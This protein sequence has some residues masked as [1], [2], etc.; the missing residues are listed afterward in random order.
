MIPGPLH[1]VGAVTSGL[2][3]A[4]A[5]FAAAGHWD[6][7]PRGPA[8]GKRTMQRARLILHENGIKCK[9][10]NDGFGNRE[11]GSGI[12]P[13]ARAICPPFLP[14]RRGCASPRG[15]AVRASR[16][17]PVPGGGSSPACCFLHVYVCIR[18]NETG[19]DCI[20]M[21]QLNNTAVFLFVI[22]YFLFHPLL[23][24]AVLL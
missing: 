23:D 14:A 11:Q 7:V 6:P 2:Q 19:D 10:Q 5:P 4:A 3:P 9:T 12:P 22:F 15:G 18:P 21:W 1:R 20:D 24:K 13:A 17:R 16:N 8:I